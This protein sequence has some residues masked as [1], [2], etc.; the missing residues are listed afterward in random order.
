MVSFH[1]SPQGRGKVAWEFMGN[2]Q[3]S[4][5]RTF[6]PSKLKP[7]VSQRAKVESDIRNA[8]WLEMGTGSLSLHGMCWITA[9][10]C[11]CGY[12]SLTTLHTCLNCKCVTNNGDAFSSTHW[13]SEGSPGTSFR[14]SW[15]SQWTLWWAE[16]LHGSG[17]THNNK[18]TETTMGFLPVTQPHVRH[19]WAL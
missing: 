13:C 17:T 9:F 15:A 16:D 19:V 11:M 14:L 7:W 12:F 3:D 2:W 18:L 4:A 5:K 6:S 10:P 8:S 1:S